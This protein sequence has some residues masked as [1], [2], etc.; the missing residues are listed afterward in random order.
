MSESAVTESESSQ[1]PEVLVNIWFDVRCPWCFLG[2]RRFERAVEQFSAIH[3][4]IPVTVSH[5]SFELAPGIPER[6][7][8][9]EAEYLL[10]YEGVPLEQ[11]AQAL[12]AL[13]KL[14]ASEGVEL[15]FD[16]LIEVNTRKAHRVFQYGQSVGKGEE[17]L[18]RL[19]VAYFSECRDLADP[20]V[21]ADLA[22]ELGLDREVAFAAASGAAGTDRWDE[23]V[24]ADD[25]RGRM[26]G[27]SG[28]PFSLFNAKY[29]VS[30]A[31]SA[32]V[33]AQ[34]LETLIEREFGVAGG[35]S[36]A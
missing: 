13:Q 2:K 16:E 11:S 22:S 20:E 36:G 8:G 30:G 21:L 18:E 23:A 17:L 35:N 31:Q 15:R 33:F 26:L 12:P 3:P 24:E 29:R 14:A 32:E 25:V 4:D 34:A 9:G 1:Q 27:A 28:V 10:H 7:N 19:F 6:F 5:H